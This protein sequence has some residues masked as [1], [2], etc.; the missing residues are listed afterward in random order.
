MFDPLQLIPLI[1]GVG[2]SVFSLCLH[3]YH[4]FHDSTRIVTVDNQQFFCDWGGDECHIWAVSHP[5]YKLIHERCNNYWSIIH[6]KKSR[7]YYGHYENDLV[8]IVP[9]RSRKKAIRF[10][11]DWLFEKFVAPELNDN[12]LL[13]K[14]T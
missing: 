7:Y 5:E 2:F 4:F 9:T 14:Y 3:C 11:A 1:I 12:T 6:A 10:Y 13:N 8:A